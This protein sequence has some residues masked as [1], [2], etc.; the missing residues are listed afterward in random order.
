LAFTPLKW[1]GTVPHRFKGV[2]VEQNYG[3]FPTRFIG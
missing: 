2:K 1:W 3:R